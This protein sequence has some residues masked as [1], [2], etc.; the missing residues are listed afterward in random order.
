MTARLSPADRAPLSR[1]DGASLLGTD[2]ASLSGADRALLCR[3][4]ALPTVAPLEAGPAG[5]PAGGSEGGPEG[6]L[7]RGLTGCRLDEA[8]DVYAAA[9]GA[10][11]FGVV[12]RGVPGPDD[13]LR[14]GT[15]LPV[16]RAADSVPGFLAAHPSMVLRLGPALPRAATVMFNVHLDTVAGTPPASFDGTRFT[17]RGATD[18]KGPAVALL[19]GIRAAV[20]AE[21]AVGRDLAILIQAVSGEEGGTMG[22]LGTRRLV[23]AGHIGRLNVFCEPTGLRYLPRATAA[24][25]ASIRVVGDDAVDDAPERGHNATVLLGFLA[26]HVATA[27]ARYPG[28]CVAGVHTGPAHNRVYG[29]GELLVN[30]A[31]PSAAAGQE[32]TGALTDAVHDGLDRFRTAFAGL[33]PFDRTARDCHAVTEVVWLKRDLPALDSHDKVA[34]GWL[35]AAGIPP[36][37]TGRPAFTCDAI[38]L[39]DIPGVH[40]VVL[41]PGELGTNHAHADGEYAELADL[42]AFADTVS[43]LLI[44]VA[45]STGKDGSR[46]ASQQTGREDGWEAGRDDDE[47]CAR[48][49]V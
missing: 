25:T 13:V 44:E 32:L 41:G 37:P 29:S 6:E 20:A 42:D 14:A 17:G 36:W 43:R 31:Y 47:S 38:W 46:E 35:R 48:R 9:A 18:A 33:T 22:T 23:A 12:H 26:Q 39:A 34:E 30:L 24:A 1:A 4:L 16:R 2:G 27:L 21:P 3:L 5:I 11:G 49:P 45:R 8:L 40:T 19:A 15:P 7:D 10:I 28:V